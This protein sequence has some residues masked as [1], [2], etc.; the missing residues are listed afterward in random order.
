[1]GRISGRMLLRLKCLKIQ[2]KGNKFFLIKGKLD[3]RVRNHIVDGV[4]IPFINGILENHRDRVP[5]E[6]A[7]RDHTETCTW[8]TPPCVRTSRGLPCLVYSSCLHKAATYSPVV[9]LSS[10]IFPCKGSDTSLSPAAEPITPQK[11]SWTNSAFVR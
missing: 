2:Q 4:A 1:M 5:K 9:N 3:K 8:I 10:S 6:K 11:R 7:H